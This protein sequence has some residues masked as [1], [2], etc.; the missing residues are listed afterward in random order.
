MP[1]FLA[2]MISAL[3][4]WTGLEKLRQITNFSKT[5]VDLGIGM[6]FAALLV[7]SLVCIVELVT[8]VMLVF[9]PYSL[10]T[11]T[12]V[13]G[14]GIAFGIAGIIALAKKEDVV[15]NCYGRSSTM[16]GWKQIRLIPVWTAMAV[17]VY[18]SHA[19][20]FSESCIWFAAASLLIAVVKMVPLVREMLIARG[21]R[22]SAKEMYI[23]LP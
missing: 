21:D 20:S 15:C 13:C 8:A 9:C 18:F 6:K 17:V 22:L 11:P 2:W 7:A 23:W 16:L 10:A 5:I 19:R 3:L 4:F 1:E 12:L 14:L